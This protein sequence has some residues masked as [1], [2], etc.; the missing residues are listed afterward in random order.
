MPCHG[1]TLWGMETMDAPALLVTVDNACA[2]LGVSR[3]TLYKLA[4]EGQL[5]TVQ[6]G[7]ARRVPVA[8]LDDL[9]RRLSTTAAA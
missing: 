4:R 1:C 7:A 9:V 5:V 3:S 8:A 2:R 6:I